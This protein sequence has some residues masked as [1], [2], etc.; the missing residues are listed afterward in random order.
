MGGYPIKCRGSKSCI[1]YYFSY[2]Q[3]RNAWQNWR[4]YGMK[5]NE[6]IIFSR[7]R[8][9]YDAIFY[10]SSTH[11]LHLYPPELYM[12][13]CE[14]L[15]ADHVYLATVEHLPHRPSIEKGVL[16]ICIGENVRLGY[17]K[18]RASIIII[19]K[20]VDF[21]AS[22]GHF[23]TSTINFLIGRATS[24]ACLPEQLPCKRCW[25]AHTRYFKDQFMYWMKHFTMLPVPPPSVR[26]PTL[27]AIGNPWTSMT[28]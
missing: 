12:D 28:F 2:N 20:K 1:F 14:R 25:N 21:L 24:C 6:A 8:R 4:G 16:L 26:I 18:E 23:R 17:Y 13:H 19:R 11:E 9:T 27:P 3:N 22:F 10:G 7:L 15:C 5:L